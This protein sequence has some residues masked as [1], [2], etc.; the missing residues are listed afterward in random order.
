MPYHF[1]HR[2]LHGLGHYPHLGQSQ[3]TFGPGAICLDQNQNTIDCS[4]PNCTYGD[5]GSSMHQITTGPL[6]LDEK[7]NQISCLDPN[8]KFGDCVPNA[9]QVPTYTGPRPSPTINVNLQNPL[10]APQSSDHLTMWMNSPSAIL[11]GMSN[12]GMVTIAGLAVAVLFITRGG[13]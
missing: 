13:R 8:C 12:L 2:S 3:G 6:C 11:P 10:Q 5:C 7:E 4:D 9:T 1:Y